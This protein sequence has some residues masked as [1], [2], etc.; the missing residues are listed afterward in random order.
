MR[1]KGVDTG[2]RVL[3]KAVASRRTMRCAR[4]PGVV[5]WTGR[6]EFGREGVGGAS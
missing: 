1:A 3:V 4:K 2:D 5:F 6:N